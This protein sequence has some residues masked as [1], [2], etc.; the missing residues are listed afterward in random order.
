E[1][2]IRHPGPLHDAS[3]RSPVAR[4]VIEADAILLLVNAS[5][6]D[7]E[8]NEAFAE[9]ET[10]LKAVGEGKSSARE[11]GGFPI[12]LVLT[13]CDTLATSSASLS[14]WQRKVHEKAEYAWAKF[15]TF[16]KDATNDDE[17]EAPSPFLPF[18]SVD[19]TVETVAIK[20][21]RLIDEPGQPNSPFRVA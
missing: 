15:H 9:F 19:L 5:A 11:V 16:L 21:P 4:A 7:D 14:S 6:E 20:H 1:S 12:F 13:H 10:F 8:L 3:T 18:G 17:D 2:L